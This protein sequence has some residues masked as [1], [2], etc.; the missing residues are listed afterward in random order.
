VRPTPRVS[1]LR[2]VEVVAGA[3]IGRPPVGSGGQ[4]A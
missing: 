1:S 2:V 4:S 3:V